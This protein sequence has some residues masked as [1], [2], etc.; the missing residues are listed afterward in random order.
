MPKR[1]RVEIRK[2]ADGQEYQAEYDTKNIRAVPLKYR[3]LKPGNP[4]Y[5]LVIRGLSMGLYVKTVATWLGIDTTTI[6]SAARK[7]PEMAEALYERGNNTKMNI[8]L[9]VIKKAAVEDNLSAQIY[10]LSRIANAPSKVQRSDDYRSPDRFIK[11][12]IAPPEWVDSDDDED[13]EETESETLT[14]EEEN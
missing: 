11:M 13:D 14:E 2:T 7:Y 5:D 1:G 12:P 10:Y 4:L 8:L 9:K 6:Y 3:H